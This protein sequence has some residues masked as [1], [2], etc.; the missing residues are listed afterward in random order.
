MARKY[1][2]KD[3][4]IGEQLELTRNHLMTVTAVIED[5]PSNTH[6]TLDFVGS[7]LAQFSEIAK[8]DAELDCRLIAT[9]CMTTPICG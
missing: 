8:H 3:A 2:G 1:F 4:P 9:R 6:L 5:L 7:G